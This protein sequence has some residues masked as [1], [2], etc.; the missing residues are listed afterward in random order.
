M[1]MKW[2]I[3]D[4]QR[5]TTVPEVLLDPKGNTPLMVYDVMVHELPRLKSTWSPP[6]KLTAKEKAIVNVEGLVTI[7]GR[8]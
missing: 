3:D 2:M 8:R 6:M 7:I 4:E 1:E 5:H